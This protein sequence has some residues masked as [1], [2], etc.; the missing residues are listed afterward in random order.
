MV[1]DRLEQS[2]EGSSYKVEE[3]SLTIEA[4]SWYI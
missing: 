3:V 4:N 1:E 2:D